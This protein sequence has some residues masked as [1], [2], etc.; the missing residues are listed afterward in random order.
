MARCLIVDDSEVIR[1]VARHII[2]GLH[3]EIWEAETGELALEQCKLLMPEVILLD[4]QLP[5]LTVVE[6]LSALR[7]S[8]GG[9][10]P[11]VIY[12]TTEND[13][14]DIQR[15]LT[16]GADDYLIKPFDRASLVG[17]FS[18]VTLIA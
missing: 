7:F 9:K 13:I 5:D 2:A 16:A 11:F 18:E 1:K 14:A 6:F 8:T 15:A 3:Y 17:K 12:C 10:R 4:W